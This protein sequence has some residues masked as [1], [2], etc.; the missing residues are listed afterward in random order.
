MIDRDE[1]FR[2]SYEDWN[3][4]RAMFAAALVKNKLA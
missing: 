4:L 2:F 1:H 3:E